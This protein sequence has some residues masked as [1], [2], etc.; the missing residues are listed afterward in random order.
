MDRIKRLLEVGYL[1]SQL[2]PTFT[3]HDLAANHATYYSAWVAL[4]KKPPKGK[5]SF[6]KAETGKPELFSVARVGHQRRVTSL[7]NPITQTYLAT[8]I[9]AHWGDFIRHYRKSRLSASHPRFLAAGG[10]AANIASMQLLYDQKIMRSAG[11]RFMLRTD[12][13]RFFPTIYTHSVPWALHTKDVAKKDKDPSGPNFGNLLDLALRQG[14]DGQTIG[15]PIGPDTSHIIAEAIATSI[16]L[17]FRD[18]LAAWPSGFR[19]VDDYYLFFAT[20]K[21]ADQALAILVQVLT[22][23]ELQ[24]NFEKTVTCS[25]I[26]ISDDYW[27]HKLRNFEISH[28]RRRQSSDINHFFE[29]AKELAKQ[30]SDESVMVYALKRVSSTVV[31]KEAWA[32]FEAHVCHVAL[33]YPN[34]LQTVAR[35]LST[36][37]RI[38]YPLSKARIERLV[39]S[40]IEDHAPLGHHS[41]VV[42]C[43]WMCKDLGLSLSAPNIDLVS[44]MRSSVCALLLLDLYEAGKLAKAPD[45]THWKSSESKEALHGELWLLAYEAG[46]RGWAGFSDAHV[47]A[48]RH[49]DILRRA[50]VRFYNTGAELSPMFHVKATAMSEYQVENV[51]DL[52]DLIDIDD[53]DNLVEYDEGDGGYEGVVIPD[54]VDEHPESAEDDL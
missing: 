44:Q 36:Y 14:Q 54:E 6:P 31:R 12:I 52:F 46:V 49:F 53:L 15:I 20:A 38:G 48:N 19:Y 37:F 26:E 34:T 51:A 30:N 23:F 41:E 7:P 18:K 2:P 1:P 25:V 22:Q 47:K 40:V 32:I 16:D 33:A 45:T 9:I 43:L 11:Y 21:E 50:Q 13:S 35:L 27:T 8:N 24:I 39:N 29:L 5:A 28:G 3:T 10:R 4:Q 42:W 17:E